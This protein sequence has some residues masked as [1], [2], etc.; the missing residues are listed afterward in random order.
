MLLVKYLCV[1]SVEHRLGVLVLSGDKDASINVLPL[2]D[3]IGEFTVGK[4]TYFSQKILGHGSQ[5]TVVFK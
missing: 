1:A 4:I 5:G 3:S 2:I